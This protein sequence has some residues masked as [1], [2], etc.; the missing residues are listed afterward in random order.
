MSVQGKMVFGQEKF[1]LRSGMTKACSGGVSATLCTA[2]QAQSPKAPWGPA[3][4][5]PLH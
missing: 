4:S 3:L 2:G 1:F 5:E